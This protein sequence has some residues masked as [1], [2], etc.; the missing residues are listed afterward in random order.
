MIC[1]PSP[2][3]YD[4]IESPNPSTIKV[5]SIESDQIRFISPSLR[6]NQVVAYLKSLKQDYELPEI[7][8]VDVDAE[9]TINEESID[10]IDQELTDSN[11]SKL[12]SWLATQIESGKDI[13]MKAA[14]VEVFALPAIRQTA[15]V[16]PVNSPTCWL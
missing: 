3:L 11:D 2:F 7:A 14:L 6:A 9:K 15:R 16:W 12:P 8:F 5:D 4:I 10:N 13:Y 1:P